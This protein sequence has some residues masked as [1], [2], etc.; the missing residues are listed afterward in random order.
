MNT[1]SF[2]KI[3]LKFYFTV[4]E[5]GS[6]GCQYKVVKNLN[7]FGTKWLVYGLF[8]HLIS[9]FSLYSEQKDSVE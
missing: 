8:R 9:L 3:I 5:M 7:Y 6:S 2:L 1:L 4:L